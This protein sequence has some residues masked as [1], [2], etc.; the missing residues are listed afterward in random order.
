MKYFSFLV[1]F[2]FLIQASFAQEAGTQ[3]WS[4]NTGDF[5][6]GAPAI[7]SD[8]TVYVASNDHYL[9]AINPNGSQRWKFDMGYGAY[10]SPAIGTDGAIYIG[11]AGIGKLFALNP[12]GT[13]KWESEQ[14]DGWIQDSPAIASDGTIVFG[15]SNQN[16]YGI[17]P[18]GTTR[19]KKVVNSNLYS[20]PAIASDGTIYLGFEYGV[21]FR[22]FNSDGSEKWNADI[23]VV[24]SSPAIGSDG[25]IYVGS[26]NNSLYAINPDG[27]IKWTFAT[28]ASV[29][30]SP[31][32]GTDGTI[33]IGSTDGN[34][35]AVNPD[36][37]EKWHIVTDSFIPFMHEDSPAIGADGTIYVTAMDTTQFTFKRFLYAINP[38][39]AVAWRFYADALQGQIAI[40]NDG[41]VYVGSQGGTLYAL[42]SNSQGL[43]NSAWPRFHHDNKG[44][45]NVKTTTSIRQIDTQIPQDFEVSEV[46]PNPFNPSAHVRFHLNKSAPVQVNI[47]N[48]AGQMVTQLLNARKAA[49]NYELSWNAANFSSGVYFIKVQANG[50]TQMR[51]ALLVK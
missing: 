36:G 2:L 46:Y 28:G 14:A 3:K 25:T 30:A 48:A 35:Y 47:Y 18:D 20:S 23:G 38:N 1:I 29:Y 41:T 34:F 5:I 6:F 32:I 50:I 22:A 33:Y 40:A 49:G 17:N 51:K 44:T 43:A 13:K 31:A 12:D 37:T 26:K 45:G 8:G 42:Y 15:T 24:E 21:G 27:T 9:Y 39:G 11:T 4:F 10:G 19:W 7:G 16:F